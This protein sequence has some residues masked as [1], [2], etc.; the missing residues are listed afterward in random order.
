MKKNKSVIIMVIGLVFIGIAA[1]ILIDESSSKPI[2]KNELPNEKNK[3]ELEFES[4]IGDEI[5]ISSY[6][7]KRITK[8]KDDYLFGKNIENR[9]KIIYPLYFEKEGLFD[10]NYTK[11]YSSQN[12]DMTIY[13]RI[14]EYPSLEDAIS[15]YEQNNFDKDF[16]SSYNYSTSKN[17][18]LINGKEFKSI[19]SNAIDNDNN[20]YQSIYIIIKLDD[21]NYFEITY[22]LNN[23]VYNKR[24]ISNVINDIKIENTAKYLIFDNEEKIGYLSYLKNNRLKKVFINLDKTKYKEIES[25][26]ND[27]NRTGFQ[28]ISNKEKVNLGIIYEYEESILDT[29]E[30]EYN[31][32]DCL[33]A[34]KIYDGKEILILS[35][36]KENIFLTKL[37]DSVYLLVKTNNSFEEVCDLFDYK[38][39]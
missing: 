15:Y 23:K 4:I 11:F 29:I 30:I 24:D 35:K 16:Y 5:D 21:S 1:F 8:S 10:S 36:N 19:L 18:E 32:A 3:I 38:V 17:K 7:E 2:T 22:T 25:I 28:Y 39:V 27:L 13:S 31:F 14:S 37:E 6:E 26:E 9:N 34:N 33:K 20:F 12:D